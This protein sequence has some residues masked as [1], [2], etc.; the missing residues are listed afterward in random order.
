MRYIWIGLFLLGGWLPALAQEDLQQAE[1]LYRQ[2]K[3]SAALGAYENLLK[4]HPK[5]PFVYYNIGNCYFKMGSKG[6]A[7]A[8]YYRAFRLNPRDADI[9]HNLALSLTNGGEQLVPRGM[10]VILHK[11][12]YLLSY[13]ELTGLV[14]GLFWLWCIGAGVALLC[15]KGW[16]TVAVGTVLCAG[17]AIW[18]YVRGQIEHQPL[19]V[20]ASPTAE[21]RS[22]PG[23]NFP[24]SANVAQGHLIT[25]LDR[26]DAWHQ[27][28]VTSQGIKGWIE[29]SAVEKI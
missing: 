13:A 20:V 23:T 25:I 27:V 12:F 5:D 10:P 14:Y 11:A 26:K 22:G 15:R 19:A 28:V 16:R 3:F 4:T 8:N 18:W 29:K 7:V 2:G 9:R 21:I 1:A 6:L 24:A 17:A